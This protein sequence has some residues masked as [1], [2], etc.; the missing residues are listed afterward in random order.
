MRDVPECEMFEV[1]GCYAVRRHGFLI[2][3]FKPD[4][5]LLAVR[6]MNGDMLVMFEEYYDEYAKVVDSDNTGCAQ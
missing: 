1:T 6:N 2:T 3:G 4:M 5:D